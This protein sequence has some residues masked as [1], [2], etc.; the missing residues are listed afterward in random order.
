MTRRGCPGKAAAPSRAEPAAGAQGLAGAHGTPPDSFNPAQSAAEAGVLAKDRVVT[1]APRA[2]LAALWRR[3]R[4]GD[5]VG[6][7]GARGGRPVVVVLAALPGDL[8]GERREVR[9]GTGLKSSNPTHG[10]W[11]FIGP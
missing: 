9:G 5:E 8:R 3:V 2:A 6:L 11:G 1:T 4:D 7:G 10:G